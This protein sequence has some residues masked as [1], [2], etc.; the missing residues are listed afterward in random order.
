MQS[1]LIIGKPIEKAKNYAFDFCLKN[2]ID[3]IDITLIESEKA[4]GIAL[5]RDFQKRIF[6]KPFKSDQKA[7]IL[8]AGNGITLESQNALLK[9]LE[10]PPKNTI[11]ILLVE[12]DESVLPT[13]L[14]RCKIISLD[15]DAV[16]QKDLAEYEKILLSLKNNGVGDRLRLAEDHSKTKEEALNFIEG[17]ILAAENI[18]QKNSNKEF[19]KAIT[20]MQ[21]TYTEIKSTNSNLRL[22]IENLL[23]NLSYKMV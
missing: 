3:K 11:I 13:I 4:V 14:S 10:E 23:L 20:L 17:L 19:L 16:E 6:L 9:V 15:K 12:S 1:L 21:K 5:V 2:K 8:E 7:V 18:L 22:A